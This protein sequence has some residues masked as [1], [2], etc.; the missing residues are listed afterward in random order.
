MFTS[1]RFLDSLVSLLVNA[2]LKYYT[3]WAAEPAVNVSQFNLQQ[4]F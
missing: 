1:E 3:M 2:I 4:H